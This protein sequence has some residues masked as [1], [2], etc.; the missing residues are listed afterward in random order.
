MNLIRNPRVFLAS[1]SSGQRGLSLIELMVAMVIGILLLIGVLDIFGASRAAFSTAEGASRVQENSRFAMDFLKNDIRMAAHSGWRSGRGYVADQF[2]FNHTAAGNA[3]TNALNAPFATRIHIPIQ[4]YEFTG[5]A[6]GQAYNIS[7]GLGGASAANFTPALPPELAALAGDAVAG[8]DVLVLR[9]LSGESVPAIHLNVAASTLILQ[10]ADAGFVEQGQVYAAANFAMLAL[11]QARSGGAVVNIGA[12]GLN[13][14]PLMAEEDIAPD[15]HRYNYIV[16]Y[17]GFDGVTREPSLRQRV[18]APGNPGLLSAPVTLVE[19]V[20]SLQFV[21]GVD[22]GPIFD[23]V[24]DQYQTAAG[25]NALNPDP[26]LAWQRVMSVRFSVLMRSTQPAAVLRDAASPPIR[27]ADTTFQV[28]DDRRIR[29]VF[30]S[31]T[32]VRNQSRN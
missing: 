31:V 15:L 3:R 28:P 6:P 29:Q 21:Y 9:F 24:P 23:E 30:E 5:T 18:L 12:G 19:G 26:R 25:V 22:T 17:V 7:G 13:V 32:A 16:Y 27:V 1:R 11:F 14:S 8:S 4:G 20:E 2:L 10:P